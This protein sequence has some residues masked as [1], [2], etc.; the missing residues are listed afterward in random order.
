MFAW[1]SV[2]IILECLRRIQPCT[3]TSSLI[4]NLQ[5]GFCVAIRWH[6]YIS[7]L[8]VCLESKPSD[9]ESCCEAKKAMTI[10]V[11]KQSAFGKD[12]PISEGYRFFKG[13]LPHESCHRFGG[14]TNPWT[15]DRSIGPGRVFDGTLPYD[16][17]VSRISVEIRPQK[18]RPNS[19]NF[20][21]GVDIIVNMKSFTQIHIW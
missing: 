10:F 21:V 2:Y 3:P 16:W 6:L 8:P 14:S 13:F 4:C 19:L 1:F 15:T 12:L 7:A 18:T 20:E 5:P 9:L 11:H 17:T